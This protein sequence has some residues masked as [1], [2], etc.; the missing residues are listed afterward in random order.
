MSAAPKHLQ[1]VIDAQ[2]A[3]GSL[4]PTEEQ[5]ALST[6]GPLLRALVSSVTEGL[7]LELDG[8]HGLLTAWLQDGLHYDIPLV[9]IDPDRARLARTESHLYPDLRLAYHAQSGGT[10]LADMSDKRFDL[11]VDHRLHDSPES[12]AL[13]VDRLAN[14]GMAVTRLTPALLQDMQAS[15]TPALARL[16]WSNLSAGW[17]MMAVGPTIPARRGGRSGRMAARQDRGEPSLAAQGS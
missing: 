11:I 7:I 3:A 5:Q 9:I 4:P 6:L 8:G 14:G 16:R 2:A 13:L 10:F 1:P 12:F 17:L 15:K